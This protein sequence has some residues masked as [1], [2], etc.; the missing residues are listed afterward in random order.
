MGNIVGAAAKSLRYGIAYPELKIGQEPLVVE[1]LRPENTNLRVAR[2]VLAV[3]QSAYTVQ[4]E[5]P[6]GPLPEGT[7]TKYR[8]DPSSR[9]KTL[10][11]LNRMN[12]HV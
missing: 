4:L 11:H 8:F 9:A 12:P 2:A 1:C 10:G 6:C 7:V 3:I 5:E